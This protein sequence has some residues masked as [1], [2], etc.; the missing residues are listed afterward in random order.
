[1]VY[2]PSMSDKVSEN[3]GFF[4]WLLGSGGLK[5]TI[6]VPFVCLIVAG[7]T[8]GWLLYLRGSRLALFGAVDGLMKETVEH[9]GDKVSDY[10]AGAAA[11]ASLNAS[12][13]GASPDPASSLG[14]IREVLRHE[15]LDRADIDIAALGF[16]DGEYAEAQRMPG[17]YVRI[18][19]AGRTTGGDLVLQ[20]TDADGT[21]IVVELR[22]PGY[23]PRTRPW[24]AAAKSAPGVVFTSPYSI[25][26]T[27]ELAMAAVA[28][29]RVGDRLRAAAAVDLRM[30]AL[31]SFLGK[32]DS[33]KGGLAAIADRD[34]LLIAS[35]DE[36]TLVD[37][38]GNRLRAEGAAGASGRIFKAA[39]S[40]PPSKVF[41]IVEGGARYRAVAIDKDVGVG[42]RWRIV[43]ALPESMFTAPLGQTDVLAFLVLFIMLAIALLLAFAAAAHVTSPLRQL[44]TAIASLDP[45]AIRQGDVRKDPSEAGQRGRKIAEGLA[46]RPDEIGRLASAF[47]AMSVRLDEGFAS[48]TASLRE[49]EVLLKEVHHR[50]KNNLQ[51]VSS[52]LSLEEGLSAD[53]SVG[54]SLGRIQD[55]IQAMAFVHE[56]L[57]RSGD[58]GSV[59]MDAYLSRICESLA[60]GDRGR[61]SIEVVTRAEGIELSL[62]KA[63]PCGLIVNELV[64]NALKH[65][66]AGRAEGR[67]EVSLVSDHQTYLLTVEDDGVG[68]PSAATES[69][70]GGMGSQLVPSLAQQLRGSIETKSSASGTTVAL[71]F[72]S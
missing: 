9:V 14:R 25:V 66:F 2:S 63:L 68:M 11:L 4:R 48:V 31:S 7:F 62:E 59:R 34:G 41:G 70:R 60:C 17:G 28:P 30:G 19:E 64:T 22:S 69:R 67:V 33:I 56:D 72:P 53:P 54:E 58:F 50:V 36:S 52:M 6:L 57:Y 39:A 20:R 13:F 35:S 16:S 8:S 71:R 46:L 12:F 29:F 21:P 43:I 61:C 32:M 18:G 26:S 47:A 37:A 42:L 24:F 10:L 40:L 1:V 3:R 5:R 45:E 38:A 27:G 55:R 49:K 44:G 51:I 23:D 15:L 65:A